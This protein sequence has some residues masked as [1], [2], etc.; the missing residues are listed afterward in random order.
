M[1][2]RV[3]P[4]AGVWDPAAGIHPRLSPS[5]AAVRHSARH[6]AGVDGGSQPGWA[7]CAC[8]HT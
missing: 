1:R 6:N 7:V 4:A 2:K 5:A 3:D 8:K